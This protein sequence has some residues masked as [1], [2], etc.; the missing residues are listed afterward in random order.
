MKIEFDEAK[1]ER[2]IL[3]RGLPFGMVAEFEWDTALVI[4]DDRMN[5]GEK[6]YRAIG[7]IGERLH[8]IVFTPRKG[9]IRVI[10]LRKAN[11][12]EEKGYGKANKS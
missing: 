7:F 5:Y 11:K 4:E 6:R 2:N 10:S 9:G 3:E 8:A 12:R 1:N